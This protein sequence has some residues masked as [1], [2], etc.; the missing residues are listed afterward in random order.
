MFPESNA[1]FNLNCII[2]LDYTNNQFFEKLTNF[3]QL[4]FQEGGIIRLRNVETELKYLHQLLSKT[5]KI[6][7]IDACDYNFKDIT[8]RLLELTSIQNF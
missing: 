3:V 1:I 6:V 5:T 8:T 2:D 7:E 4:P